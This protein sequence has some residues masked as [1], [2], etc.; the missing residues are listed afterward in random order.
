MMSPGTSSRAAGVIH[1][2]A[3]LVFLP[4]SDHSVGQKLNE[5]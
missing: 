2:V 1:G 4:E 5:D 3:R